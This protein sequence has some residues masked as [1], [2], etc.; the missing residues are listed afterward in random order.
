ML[1][2]EALAQ[3]HTQYIRQLLQRELDNKTDMLQKEL[4][5]KMELYYEAFIH[6]YKH[7]KNDK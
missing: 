5:S 1:T 3:K 2:A 4:D 7:G 6:G